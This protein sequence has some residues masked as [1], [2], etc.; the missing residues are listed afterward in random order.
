MSKY[1]ATSA[2]RG[3]HGIVNEADVM[4]KKALEELGPDKPVAFTNTAY[5]LPV[6][7]GFL[8][9]RVEKLGDLVTPLEHAKSLLPPVPGERLWLP[10]L[11]ETLDSGI[12]TL[13]AEEIVEGIRFARGTEP[14][15]VD[16]YTYN[17]PIDDIQLRAWGIQLVDGRMP[18]FAAIVGAAKNNETA[19]KIVRELQQRNILVFLSGNVNGRSIIDQ[20]RE[21]GVE[22]GYDTYTVPFGRDTIS[23]IY[24]LGFATRSAL[25]FGGLKAGQPREILT[26]QQS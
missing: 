15:T 11:G 2:I 6:I 5:H 14:L 24:A 12:S 21:E 20:L 1:I 9:Q 22:L 19:V 17:G 16:G 13:L 25:T 26:L 7:L 4:L 8:G 23:A 18:G 3:A 10:Y